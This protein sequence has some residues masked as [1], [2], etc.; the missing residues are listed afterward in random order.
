MC[1]YISKHGGLHSARRPCNH[2][3]ENAIRH[4]VD[5][6]IGWAEISIPADEAAGPP[7]N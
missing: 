4:G 1:L 5:P 2:L 6:K 3:V 7:Y